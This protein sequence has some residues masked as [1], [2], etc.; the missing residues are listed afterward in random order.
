[1]KII[2]EYSKLYDT[3]LVLNKMFSDSSIDTSYKNIQISVQDDKVYLMS[4]T[5]ILGYKLHIEAELF[6]KQDI[7]LSISLK[8]LIMFLA[9]YKKLSYYI[10]TKVYFILEN[11]QLHC[12]VV[13]ENTETKE[14]TESSN[15]FS[16]ASIPA[17]IK[18]FITAQDNYSYQDVE[19]AKLLQVCKTLDKVI[20]PTIQG[21]NELQF[22]QGYVSARSKSFVMF[23]KTDL[24]LLEGISMTSKLSKFLTKFLPSI[25]DSVKLYKDDKF[26]YIKPS[27]NE[28]IYAQYLVRQYD[29]SLMINTFKNNVKL[30]ITVDKIRLLE[31]LRRFKL[32]KEPIT[33]ELKLKDKSLT[34]KTSRLTQAM[35]FISDEE[36]QDEEYSLA[37]SSDVLSQIVNTVGESNN[38]KISLCKT[39]K[40]TLALATHDE[41]DDWFT[42]VN[43]KILFKANAN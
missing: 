38:V 1:M 10:A 23:L 35:S 34:L 43:A 37:I 31:V 24:E 28:F 18:N 2:F 32:Y 7:V 30:S 33:I 27:D 40:D 14:C 29:L 11:N 16:L 39:V 41:S 6:D 15:I 4:L 3:L 21:F 42:Y 26:L 19:T 22:K 36:M 8:E 9:T 13:E 12:T 5:P 17:T 20:Q 25:K